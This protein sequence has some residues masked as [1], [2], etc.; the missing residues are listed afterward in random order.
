MKA[1]SSKSNSGST[2]TTG[3]LVWNHSTHLEGLIPILKRLTHYPGI[4]TITPGVITRVKAHSPKMQI[5]ISV[6]ILG[7]F[8][9]IARQGKTAQEVF[10]VTEL[11]QQQLEEAIAACLR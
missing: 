3:R 7:G 9:A 10:F 6:P 5:R 4:T 2:Q 1:K 8:K 11:Q